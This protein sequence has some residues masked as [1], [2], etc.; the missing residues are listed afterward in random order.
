MPVLSD[1]TAKICDFKNTSGDFTLDVAG[2]IILDA[3]N[4]D[5][6]LK[7]NGTEFG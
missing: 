4:A 1:I 7:D 2:D 6:I 5:V 3:D